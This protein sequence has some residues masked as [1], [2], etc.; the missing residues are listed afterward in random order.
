MKPNRR[1]AI[2]YLTLLLF[3]GCSPESGLERSSN[4]SG[5][6]G[7]PGAQ[8]GASAALV[9]PPRR[10]VQE[11]SAA[12]PGFTLV[13]P[14]SSKRIHLLDMAGQEVHHWDS[15]EKSGESCYLTDRGTL[16]RCREV[17]D[18]PTFQ[19]AGGFG[20]GIFE[21]GPK[22]ELLW[23]FL[24][25]NERGLQHHD[26]EEL[27]NGNVLFVAW[28]RN[29]REDALAAGRDPELLEGAEWWSGAIYEVRPTRPVGGEIVWSWHSRDHL[30]QNYDRDLVGYG[31]PSAHPGRIDIN[32]ERDPEAPDKKEKA[33]LDA[34]MKATGY[35]GG[36]D[37][38]DEPADDAV[39]DADAGDANDPADPESPVEPEESEAE[40][41]KKA[42][43]KARKDRVRDADWT[44][45]NAVAYNA[46]L[47]Q[48]V[49]SSRRF[50][51]V[52]II[53]HDCT[54]AEAAGPAGDLIYRF[55]NAF[56][57]GMGQ[58]SE[59][60]FLG[61]HNVQWIPKGQLG[62]GNLI[63][64]N[65]GSRPRPWSSIVEWWAPRDEHGR[66]VRLEGQPF[67]PSQYEWS[68]QAK[69]VES[70]HAPF[71]SGVQRLPNGN[72]LLCDGPGGEVFEVTQEGKTVWEWK[73][74]LEP[75]GI[76]PD[77][78]QE[79]RMRYALFRVTR[80]GA[81][82]P[83]IQA[84]RDAGVEIPESPGEA[85][86]VEPEEPEGSE[87]SGGPD[88]PKEP[89]EPEEASEPEDSGDK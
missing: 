1:A 7:A 88:E 17:A 54:E 32:G 57:Y 73:N 2:T 27:P 47:D 56:A 87:E 48:I 14:I 62:E 20:G 12:F 19:D 8:G 74:D 38:V 81:D 45:F 72:T 85:P 82:S 22:G 15:T 75:H 83:G 50:D 42:E 43:D 18:H 31:D 69:D 67:G 49:V 4:S 70:F 33:K 58:W 76:D 84:L 34:Q 52:W 36:D 44:H 63:V 68:Y 35:A 39:A 25:D 80:Y 23:E 16:L 55:G 59:R 78:E 29:T 40:K 60:R 66:Y 53:D 77:A 21:Y 51:E 26:I 71:I 13:A 6:G 64:F 46:E 86:A 28:D 61:Q 89:K 79:E 11:D 24:W 65:N 9:L 41:A 30:I 10:Q 37:P 5:G 3:F